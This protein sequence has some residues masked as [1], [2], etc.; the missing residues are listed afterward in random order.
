MIFLNTK[1][2]R[3]TSNRYL[4]TKELA[5]L[6]RLG[7]R[8]VYNLSSNGDM[9]CVRNVGKLIFPQDTIH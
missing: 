7:E 8:K 1:V 5:H 2:Q 4:T 9:P 3:C 6:L